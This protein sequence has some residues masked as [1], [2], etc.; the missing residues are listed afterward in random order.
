MFKKS[1]LRGLFDKQH[2]KRAEGLLKSASQY[3]Y[4]TSWSYLLRTAN[5]IELEKLSPIDMQN[6]G[7]P[8]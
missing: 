4:H 6:L 1:H 8:C 7:T 3:L 2:G 5:S